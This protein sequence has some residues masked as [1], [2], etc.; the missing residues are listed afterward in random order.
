MALV[1]TSLFHLPSTNWS[2][3]VNFSVVYFDI[4]RH[5]FVHMFHQ[6]HLLG[7]ITCFFFHLSIKDSLLIGF[8]MYIKNS[9][10]VLA[11]YWTRFRSVRVEDVIFFLKQKINILYLFLL[12]ALFIA[13][14]I[15]APVSCQIL[16]FKL[17]S[18]KK[19]LSKITHLKLG[20]Y[21]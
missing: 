16:S 17:N 18:S 1:W 7:N 14:F 6:T 12:T 21:A 9:K 20:T 8:R 4:F 19:I 10:A 13:V 2:F 5:L 3:W 11:A 15:F